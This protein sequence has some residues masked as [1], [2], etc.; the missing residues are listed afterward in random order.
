MLHKIGGL[1]LH[2]V[3]Y[4][5]SS[6]IVHVY[7]SEFG[8]QSYMVQ[9]IRRKRGKFSYA[10][11]QP[12]TLLDM[13]VDHKP[14]RDLQRIKELSVRQNFHH[15]YSDIGKNTIALFIGEVLYRSLRDTEGNNTI[16]DYLENA[17]QILDI[18]QEGSMNF[19]LLFMV[20]FTRFIGI[21]PENPEELDNFQPQDAEMKVH[22]LVAYTLKDLH[23]LKI[24]KQTRFQ[25]LNAIVDYYYYHIEGMGKIS[26]LKV[27][28]E[29]FS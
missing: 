13:V 21:F 11:F 12:L 29:V 7:T 22:D 1:V 9:G 24:S 20:Q 28:H 19:H 23:K 2:A 5:E 27:L 15:I 10:H 14:N 17:V 4:T 25:M 3:K 6:V 16:F 18:C 26:S 8:R